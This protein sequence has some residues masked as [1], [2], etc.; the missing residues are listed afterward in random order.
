MKTLFL[1]PCRTQRSHAACRVEAHVAAA[2]A[3]GRDVGLLEVPRSRLA[4]YAFFSRLPRADVIVVHRE[5]LSG[6]ELRTLRRLTPRLVYDFADAVWTLPERELCCGRARRRAAQAGRR[7]ER[8]CA[9]ADLCLVETMTQAKAAAP[10]QDQVRI[11]PTPLDTSLYAPA[12]GAGGS[13]AIRVGWMVTGGDRQRLGEIVGSLA[14]R[15]GPI[16]FSIVSE[17]PYDGPGKDF[18]FWSMPEPGREAARLQTMD[19]G[20]APYPD[21]AYSRAGSGLDVLRYMAC[22]VAVVAS[23]CGGAGELVD[24]GIDGFL[25]RDAGDWTR[26]VI[27][28]ADDA[29]LRRSMAEAARRKVVSRYG[30]STV[31]DRLWEALGVAP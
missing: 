1:A 17:S 4:R 14:D 2:R 21:D 15:A 27:R 7:F 24:H 28:L 9:G 11:V 31:S 6:F 5:L 3:A 29:E 12:Q 19:I 23:D 8:M 22:G 10:F 25:A 16:Q 30:L 20:L 13:G 26:H 18:V